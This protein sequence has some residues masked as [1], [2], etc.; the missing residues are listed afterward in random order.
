MEHL[1]IS[2][3]ISPELTEG[4]SLGDDFRNQQMQAVFLFVSIR[5]IRGL[6]FLVPAMPA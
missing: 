1:I 6:R 4:A 3:K 5:V 2:Q